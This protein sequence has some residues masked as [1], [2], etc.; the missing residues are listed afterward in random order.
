MIGKTI[1]HYRILEKLGEGGMGVVYKAIDTNLNRNVA[2]K[3]LPSHFTQDESTRKRFTMEAQ[4][5]SALDH[6]NICAIHEI[7][8]TPDEQLYI[9]MGYYKG[10]SLREKIKRGP[11]PLSEALN[12]IFQIAQGLKAAHEEKI[13]HRDIK[14]GNIL[15]TEKGE[16]KIVDFGLA[17][18]ASEHLTH[19]TS[20]K[21]TAAY[22]CPEQIR[23]KNVDHR[24]DIWALGVVFYE[25][26]TGHLPFQEEYPEPMMYAIVNEEP[27]S[28]THYLKDIPELVQN[29]IERLIKKDPSERYQG[30]DELLKDLVKL[31]PG[32]ETTY[33]KGF[34]E[35]IARKSKGIS[36]QKIAIPA[37]ILL[38]LFTGFLLFK[39][40]SFISSSHKP[41]PIAIISF[42]NHT[43]EKQYDYLQMAIP[44]LLISSLE[45][46]GDLRVA[47]WERLNDLLKQKGMQD[48]KI[49]DP[50]LGFE[51]CRMDGIE[52]IVLGSYT[53]AGDVFALDIKV[54]DVKTKELLQSA[55]S[56]GQGIS[57]ILT[58]QIDELSDDIFRELGVSEKISEP[59]RPISQVTTNSM[60]AYNYFIRGR[61]EFE[62]RNGENARQFLEKAVRI[63]TTFAT[64]YSYLAIEY[65][66]LDNR[67]AG[68]EAMQKA[69][70]Y[71]DKATEKER[72]YIAARSAML[73]NNQDKRYDLERKLTEK[74]PQE[75]RAHL[76]LAYHCYARRKLYPQALER[77]KKV[78]ELDPNFGLAYNQLAYTYMEM[79]EYEKATQNL[80]KY[81][82][83]NPGDA[84]V[85]DSMGELYLRMGELDRA[86]AK[87]KEAAE[88]E[89]KYFSAYR[90]TAYIYA[91]KGDYNQTMNWIDKYIKIAPSEGIKARGHLYKGFYHF[92]LGSI[93]QSLREL[94]IAADYYEALE[95]RRGLAITNRVR[96]WIYLYIGDISNG[97]KHFRNWFDFYLEHDPEWTP[98]YKA[99][100]C[101]YS[102]I[103]NL[104]E[105]KLDS[106]KAR[107][108]EIKTIL[109]HTN[110][111][112]KDRIIHLYDILRVEVLLSQGSIE[113]A[114]NSSKKISQLPVPRLDPMNLIYY[115][116]PFASL[117]DFS[118]KAY[119]RSGDLDKAI[120]EYERL[121]T[122]DPKSK[123]R[124]LI[125]PTYYFKLAKLYEERGKLN[126]AIENYQKFL[127]IWKNAD[128]GLP[129]LIDVKAR[130]A[131]LS[132]E[133]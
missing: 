68:V 101:F 94:R 87:Y 6:P 5:A 78:L 49:I 46:S 16:V 82:S 80:E 60:E 56:H 85:F 128:E 98:A 2:L 39:N 112:N 34:T 7:N 104:R 8:E 67:K 66:V 14:P 120:S 19:A 92:W 129:E 127:E 116:L 30:I 10:V 113:K 97:R 54:L 96:G 24:C 36:G 57:S 84:N 119:Q 43:G 111:I 93:K 20:S 75:K 122:F 15:I 53:K 26:L 9:C 63:D 25:M 11:I 121:I 86:L 21:G 76:D 74:Y 12:I 47:T 51:I 118:A 77:F 89:S 109:P 64:A 131:K 95:N 108:E 28:L 70:H 31:K 45:Q 18:L 114:V 61:E 91:L 105:A 83:L 90:T 132:G 1:S 65:Y 133:N 79:G 32:L 81:A 42:Q 71:S 69:R 73:E 102:G 110:P 40:S 125:H 124:R 44:N 3:F 106:A 48:V 130:L 41:K 55:S 37:V 99:E 107:L 115:N 29:I 58:N 100:F 72:L 52:T 123:D 23:G 38:I 27:I 13:I 33:K 88:V 62:R 103:T 126:K 4:A 22:M 50:D 117:R 35:A 17:K 59:K